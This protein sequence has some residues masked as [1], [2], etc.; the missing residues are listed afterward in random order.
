[1]QMIQMQFNSVSASEAEDYF[2]DLGWPLPPVSLR[3]DDSESLH[4]A[5]ALIRDA[6]NRRT[7]TIK[8]SPTCRPF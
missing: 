5:Y 2:H 8:L 3:F 7:G 6:Q 1:M 4:C